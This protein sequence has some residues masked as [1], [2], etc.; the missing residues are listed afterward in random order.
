MK[1]FL[2]FIAIALCCVLH[3]CKKSND[4]V[5]NTY[6]DSTHIDAVLIYKVKAT[7]PSPYDSAHQLYSDSLGINLDRAIGP[8]D[9]AANISGV[10]MNIFSSPE[11][12]IEFVYKP[13]TFPFFSLDADAIPTVNTGFAINKTYEKTSTNDYPT[14]PLLISMSGGSSMGNYF[15]SFPAADAKTKP[16]VTSYCKVIFT[17]K[18]T[19]T[20]NNAS[21]TMVDGIVSGY[22]IMS[23]G[24]SDANKYVQRWDFEIDFKGL[25]YNIK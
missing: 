23:Y 18:Y 8:P 12:G 5:N 21:S 10:E 20:Y 11:N 9:F 7:Q 4:P 22:Q 16:S 14:E 13:A 19:V 6:K 2:L 15:T 1:Y 24:A 25:N 3:S 17:N